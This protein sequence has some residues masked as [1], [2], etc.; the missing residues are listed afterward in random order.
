M[1]FFLCFVQKMWFKPITFFGH[2][3]HTSS[4]W[5]RDA[6]RN[7]QIGASWC[8]KC[9]NRGQLPTYLAPG[10][11]HIFTARNCYIYT[12]NIFSFQTISFFHI[13]VFALA[14]VAPLQV[15]YPIQHNSWS[16]LIYCLMV[17]PKT[18]MLFPFSHSLSTIFALLSA[19]D[20]LQRY[21]LFWKTDQAWITAHKLHELSD[22][23]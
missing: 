10:T 22:N 8:I 9:Q 5:S 16:Y 4:S 6:S 20:L 13:A 14:P 2:P 11:R 7:W 23:H 12:K 1:C 15:P 3:D 18:P 19:L 21:F 17:Y